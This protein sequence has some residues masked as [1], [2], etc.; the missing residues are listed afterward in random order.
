[1][2]NKTNQ[3]QA[4]VQQ[5]FEQGIAVAMDPVNDY[6]IQR[7]GKAVTTLN[8][9]WLHRFCPTCLHTF[10]LGDE[11]SIDKDGVVRH[12]SVLLPC[13]R[14]EEGIVEI[15]K[16]TSAFFAGLDETWPPPGD[17]RIVRLEEGHKLLA[18]PRAGFRRHTCAVCG[19]TLRLHD[20]VIICPCSP[21]EPLCGTAIH[22]D[23]VHGLHCFEAWNPGANKQHYCPVTSRK[24]DE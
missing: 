17:V 6:A 21:N 5:A 3:I 7:G 12:C 23:P 14:G 1:M 8:S 15:S 4:K 9:N 20:H 19:H 16:E 2:A 11:V 18:P 10:R 13:V 24:L 22:R